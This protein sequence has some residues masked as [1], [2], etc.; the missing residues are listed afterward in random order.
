MPRKHEQCSEKRDICNQT[1]PVSLPM[2]KNL[3]HMKI[4]VEEQHYL[5][6]VDFDKLNSVD[7]GFIDEYHPNCKEAIESTLRLLEN[8]Y[9]AE[10]IADTLSEGLDAMDYSDKGKKGKKKLQQR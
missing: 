2:V 1:I 6:M 4:S 8:V 10:E 5:F 7:G 3:F 9:S